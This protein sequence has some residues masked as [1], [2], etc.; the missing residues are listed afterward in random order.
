LLL[1]FVLENGTRKFQEN[2]KGLHLNG[3]HQ[4][5]FYADDVNMFDENTNTTKINIGNLLQKIRRLV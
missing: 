4:S 3:K 2:Q 1:N 5:S